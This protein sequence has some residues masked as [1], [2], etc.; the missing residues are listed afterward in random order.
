MA[1]PIS[2]AYGVFVKRINAV[3]KLKIRVIEAN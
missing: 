3:K 1:V 2:G